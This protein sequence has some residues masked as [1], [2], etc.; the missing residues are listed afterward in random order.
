MR[1]GHIIVPANDVQTQ[2]AFYTSLGLTTVFRD[3]DRYAAV[4]D[5]AVTIGLADATQQPV[6]GRTMLSIGV[7]DLEATVVALVAVGGKAGETVTGPHERRTVVTD[8]GGNPL[9][10][11]ERL[12]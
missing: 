7:A 4:T 3:G 9:V 11:Y 2:L 6:A 8:P 12:A 1:I 5:G 10:V